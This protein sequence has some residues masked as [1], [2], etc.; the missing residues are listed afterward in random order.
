MGAQWKKKRLFN[1]E[2]TP[3]QQLSAYS[4]HLSARHVI[5][6]VLAVLYS[7]CAVTVTVISVNCKELKTFWSHDQRMRRRNELHGSTV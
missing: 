5:L 2:T 3:C 7:N 4:V 1:K 6:P